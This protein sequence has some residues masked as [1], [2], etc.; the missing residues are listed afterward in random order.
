MI[1]LFW[2]LCALLYSSKTFFHSLNP[3]PAQLGVIASHC[4]EFIVEA[5]EL[6]IQTLRLKGH[7]IFI[8]TTHQG[9]AQHLSMLEF[10][11]QTP[12]LKEVQECILLDMLEIDASLPKLSKGVPKQRISFSLLHRLA[13]S[14]MRQRLQQQSLFYHFCRI[15]SLYRALPYR[16]SSVS[17]Q[18]ERIWGSLSGSC[19]KVYFSNNK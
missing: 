16:G 17:W 8:E 3:Q 12:L 19:P 9:P 11:E 5:A 18:T 4:W 7:Q 14:M 1:R 6:R 10:I 13:S 2:F 15:F